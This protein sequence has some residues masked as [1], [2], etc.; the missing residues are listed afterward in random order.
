VKLLLDTHIWLWSALDPVRL[1]KRVKT[2]LEDRNNELWLSPVS[3]WETLVLARKKR[4]ILESTPEQW[5][6]RALKDLPIREAPMSHEVAIRSVALRFDQ[7]DPA[8]R[9]ILATALVYDLSL[10]TADKRLVKSRQ[11]PVLANVGS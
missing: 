4:I 2:A 8:D 11:V 6:R 5:V 9:F 3:V 7:E 10:V 1:S